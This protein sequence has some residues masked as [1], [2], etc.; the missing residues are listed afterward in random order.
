L[1]EQ[2]G[3]AGSGLNERYRAHLHLRQPETPFH[4]GP[5]EVPESAVRARVARTG[6]AFPGFASR[7]RLRELD[8]TNVDQPMLEGICRL[9]SLEYLD[10]GWPLVATDLT[11]LTALKSLRHLKIDSPRK[12]TDFSP[13]AALPLTHL[14]I[15]NAKNLTSLEVLAPLRDRLVALGIEGGMYSKQTIE[16]LC[17]S[18]ASRSRRCS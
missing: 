3:S 16:S 7:T 4:E 11:P 6:K 15:S 10:L 9:E 1:A 2:E 13:V 5:G 12:L 14:F 17:R 8:A 18:K